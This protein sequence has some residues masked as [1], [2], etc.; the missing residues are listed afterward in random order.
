MFIVFSCSWPRPPD[1]CD[2]DEG[3]LS[4]LMEEQKTDKEKSQMRNDGGDECPDE[5]PNHSGHPREQ[6]SR[7]LFETDCDSGNSHSRG[8]IASHRT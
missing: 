4:L 2:D 1:S 8:R 3:L 6:N 5:R 7:G